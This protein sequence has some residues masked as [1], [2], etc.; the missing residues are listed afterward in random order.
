MS[1]VL[2]ISRTK[3][4]EEKVCVGGLDIDE[5]RSVRL[6]DN[7]GRHETADA[8][9]YNI[10]DVWDIDYVMK[11]A[12]VLPHSAEDAYVSKR[13]RLFKVSIERPDFISMLIRNGINVYE[14][15]IC[16]AFCGMLDSTDNGRLY[17]ARPNVP[18]H[19]TCFWICDRD[20]RRDLFHGINYR[21]NDGTSRWG[22]KIKYVGVDEETLEVIPKGTL[23]RLSLAHW[24]DTNGTTEDRCYLQLSGYFCGL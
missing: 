8:C 11:S 2:I 10:F 13:Q 3:M 15:N 5:H 19:S 12:T 14:G 23:I 21:Y 6:L 17:I 22:Y 9:P 18:D 1:K 4:K 20:L 16:N 24:W 7:N